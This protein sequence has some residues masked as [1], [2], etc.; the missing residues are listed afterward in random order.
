MKRIAKIIALCMV[1]FVGCAFTIPAATGTLEAHAA[2]KIKLSKTKATITKGKTLQLKVKGTKKKVKWSSSSK[3][4]AT[5]SKKGKVTAKKS[6]KVTIT[7]KV[8]KKKLKCKI[9][10]KNSSAV[11]ISNTK[12]TIL[13]GETLQLKMKGTKKKA[14]WSSSNARIATVDK[15]GEAKGK[16][17]GT[18]TIVA[19]LGKKAYLC[20]LTVEGPTTEKQIHIDFSKAKNEMFFLTVTLTDASGTKNIISNQQRAKADGSENILL[21]GHGKA[22]LTVFFDGEIVRKETIYF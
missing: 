16:R 4:I 8:G 12:A 22:T 3:K 10:V 7:A 20:T 18:T 6:G 11:K 2:S 19:Q 21:E 14:K 15:N 5:V 13:Q 17:P 1:L 9:T